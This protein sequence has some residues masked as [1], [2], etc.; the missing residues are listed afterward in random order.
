M[1]VRRSFKPYSA[2]LPFSS[3]NSVKVRLSDRIRVRFRVRIRVRFWVGVEV[4]VSGRVRG[5][6]EVGLWIG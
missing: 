2:I 4:R 6:E 3:P 5:R 1:V